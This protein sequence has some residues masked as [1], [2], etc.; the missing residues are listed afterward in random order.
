SG[1]RL[2]IEAR[3]VVLED[4]QVSGLAPGSY[5]CLS[6]GDNGSGMSPSTLSRVFE[7]FFTTK[8]A[9]KGTGLRLSMVYGFAPHAGGH[10]AIQ[11]AV[12]VGT[13]VTLYLPRAELPSPS[14][15]DPE[16]DASIPT[17]SARILVVDDNEALLKVTAAM[18]ARLGYQVVA[19]RSAAE[20]IGIL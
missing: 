4:G 18:L 15:T 17:G 10:V 12:G 8:E 7:P 1:G 2:R 16:E 6:V 20:A 11:S 13:T 14:G 9:G 3:N 5:V 19:A